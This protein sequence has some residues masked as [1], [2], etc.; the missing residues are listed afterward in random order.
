M[1]SEPTTPSSET[2]RRGKGRKTL[3]N[4]ALMSPSVAASPVVGAPAIVVSPI[5]M[6]PV[7]TPRMTMSPV[8][9]PPSTDGAA[10]VMSTPRRRGIGMKNRRNED[11]SPVLL[12]PVRLSPDRGGVDRQQAMFEFPM[13]H[14][15][16][17]ERQA[18]RE[19]LIQ[20]KPERFNTNVLTIV[21]ASSSSSS[22]EYQAV[23]DLALGASYKKQKIAIENAEIKAAEDAAAKAAKE[24]SDADYKRNELARVILEWS[25]EHMF[26]PEPG[27]ENWGLTT[28]EL[29]YK[30]KDTGVPVWDIEMDSD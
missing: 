21:A 6:S 16:S 2:R 29:Y 15:P 30:Y 12:S 23:T 26:F 5:T 3:M 13:I 20:E 17:A 28:E 25:N 1:Q 4:E 19:R 10:A 14:P 7:A 22:T 9:M 11:G 8:A 24:Q 18:L 27:D